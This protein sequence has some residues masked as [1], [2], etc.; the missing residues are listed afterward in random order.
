MHDFTRARK[1]WFF[2]DDAYVCLGA[3]IESPSRQFPVVTTINQTLL[4]GDVYVSKGTNM[5]SLDRGEHEIDDVQWVFHNGTGYLFHDST[6]IH[7]SNQTESGKWIDINKQSAS[8]KELVSKDVFALWIDH[9]VRPQ[10]NWGG[11]DYTSTIPEDVKYQYIV[12]PVTKL[13]QMNDDRGIEV[14]VNNHLIQAVKDHDSGMVQALFYQAGEIDISEGMKLSIDSPGAVMLKMSHGEAK[15][16]TVADPSRRLRRIHLQIS[17]M[18]D[19]TI[20]LPTGVN[21][22]QSVNIEL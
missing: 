15:E 4:K 11:F 17:G 2:F 10:G 3:G 16:I 13:E 22:G 12:V 20:E 7:L 5:D 18:D 19:L 1:G 14:L 9:G 8:P 21:A 6:C